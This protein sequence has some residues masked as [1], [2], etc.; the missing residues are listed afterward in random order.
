MSRLNVLTIIRNTRL[1]LLSAA[2]GAAAAC[3]DPEVPLGDDPEVADEQPGDDPDADDA[4][5]PRSVFICYTAEW[6]C[7][8]DGVD[9]YSSKDLCVSAC[10]GG[11]IKNVVGYPCHSPRPRL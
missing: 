7:L 3:D 9:G 4:V 1:F 6:E 11:C 2:L 5:E 8:A 10:S